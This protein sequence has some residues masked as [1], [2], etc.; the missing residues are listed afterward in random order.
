MFVQFDLLKIIT[1]KSK[2]VDNNQNYMLFSNTDS[3]FLP[4]FLFANGNRNFEN[5]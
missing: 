2:V 5:I 4:Q 1:D 3:E